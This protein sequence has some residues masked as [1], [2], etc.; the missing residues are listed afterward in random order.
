TNFTG[1]SAV[2][3]GS[4]AASSFT[5]YS[6]TSIVA[7]APPQAAA[8]V[9]VTVTTPGGTSS[10]ST[11]DQFTYSAASSPSIS[12]VTPSSGS[13]A[14]GVVVTITGTNFAGTTGVKFGTTA[15]SSYTVN[16]ATQITATAPAKSAATYD[17]TVTTN[18][19]TSATGSA[20]QF[21]YLSTAAPAVT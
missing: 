1:A 20:D 15:A 11:A 14:G 10:T 4:V 8:T 17:I 13:T 2:S 7:V 5:V 16:S 9:H 6:A 18:N 3:F 12:A 19:G 21:T